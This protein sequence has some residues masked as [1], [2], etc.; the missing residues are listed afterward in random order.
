MTQEDAPD[1]SDNTAQKAK[2]DARA[3][4][5]G[6]LC[7]VMST[8]SGRRFVQRL[9]DAAA[10]DRPSYTGPGAEGTA[11]REGRRSVG[12]GLLDQVRQHCPAEYL[13]MVQEAMT[14]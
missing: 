11:W 10:T 14:K 8:R 12:I 5:I 9:L 6:D 7:G 3:V 4:A 13:L 1:V 2:T